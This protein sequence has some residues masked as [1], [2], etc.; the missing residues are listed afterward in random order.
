MN[1]LVELVEWLRALTPEFAFLLVLP[2][3]VGAAGLWAEWRR[4]AFSRGRSG[5][6]RSLSPR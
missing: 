5:A 6:R 2:F 3:V 4:G 1:L